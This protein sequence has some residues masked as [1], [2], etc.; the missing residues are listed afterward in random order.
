MPFT[1]VAFHAHPDD[2]SL[3]M[4]GTIARAAAEGHRV[5]LVTATDGSAGLAD[6]E[7]GTHAE[8]GRRRL[9]ELEDAAE[10]LGAARVVHL[11]FPDGTFGSVG[12]TEP[13][14]ALAAVLEQESADVLTGYDPSGGYGHPDHVH[15]HHVARAAAATTGVA[16]LEA[17]VD[18]AL[19]VAGARL[20][21]AVPGSPPIDLARMRDSYLPRPELTHKIDVRPYVAAKIQGLAAHASQQGGSS[22]FRTV[23]LL[24]RLPGPVARRVL[25]REWFREVGR[26]PGGR[27][28]DDV[29]ASCRQ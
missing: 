8:L 2:E 1:L 19:I 22:G 14:A 12:V 24:H 13:S 18:R 3:L 9:E 26:E 5:V 7:H 4:G 11:G 10:R 15:V 16:L 28:L 20:V 6:A 21:H 23:T 17:T 29:F 25:G 27:L